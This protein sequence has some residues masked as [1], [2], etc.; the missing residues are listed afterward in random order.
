MDEVHDSLVSRT[1]ESS[2]KLGEDVLK[3]FVDEV[4]TDVVIKVDGKEIKAH[5]F[6]LVARSS[7]FS[8]LLRGLRPGK[9]PFSVPLQGYKAASVHLALTHLYSGK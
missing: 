8:T 4:D 1:I 7:Y 9:E 2:A 5:K 3:M 6:I